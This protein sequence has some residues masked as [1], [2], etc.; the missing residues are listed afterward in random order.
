MKIARIRIDDQP[1]NG[2]LDGDRFMSILRGITGDL[3]A[4][5][6]WRPLGNNE[7]LAPCEPPQLLMVL[8]GWLPLDGTPLPSGT[9]AKVTPKCCAATGDGADIVMP[10][11]PGQAGAVG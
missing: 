7:L 3:T 8:G 2:L 6:D 1:V 4:S 9:E 5:G 11:F 10:G